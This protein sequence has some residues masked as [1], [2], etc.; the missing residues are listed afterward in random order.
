MTDISLCLW[1]SEC[2][3]SPRCHRATAEPSDYWQSY[4]APSPGEAC[5]YYIPNDKGK[6]DKP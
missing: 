2:P 3:L 4:F 6:E 1:R 5:E